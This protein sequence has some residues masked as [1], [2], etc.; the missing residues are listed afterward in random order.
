MIKGRKF[1]DLAACQSPTFPIFVIPLAARRVAFPHQNQRYKRFLLFFPHLRIGERWGKKTG[2]VWDRVK[3]PVKPETAGPGQ[4]QRHAKTGEKKNDWIQIR[5]KV[6]GRW[7]SGSRRSGWLGVGAAYGP[8]GPWVPARASLPI[9]A[10]FLIHSGTSSSPENKPGAQMALRCSPWASLQFPVG[11]SR[12]S[13]LGTFCRHGP[14][15]FGQ[16]GRG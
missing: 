12:C 3:S 7:C 10:G 11:N 16:T 14:R 4:N 13:A 9:C 5:W 1:S 2:G 15:S 8:L 6:L